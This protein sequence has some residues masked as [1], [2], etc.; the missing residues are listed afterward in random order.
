M[1]NLQCLFLQEQIRAEIMQRIRTR[2]NLIVQNETLDVENLCSVAQQELSLATMAS[3][4]LNI[5]LEHINGLQELINILSVP[6][7]PAAEV[8]DIVN[9]NVRKLGP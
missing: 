8:S 6:S 1:L 9:V 3:Q 7:Q 4:H 5:P 2:F